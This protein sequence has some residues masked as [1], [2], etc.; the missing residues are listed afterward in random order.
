[1]SIDKPMP[2]KRAKYKI[3]ITVSICPIAKSLLNIQTPK[4]DPKKAPIS[5]TPPI[6]RSTRPCLQC[7]NVPEI[8]DATIWF[9]EVAT[10]T[11]VGMP[12]NI[13]NGV[14]KKPPPKPNMP[15]RN[16]TTPPKDNNRKMLTESSAIG[17]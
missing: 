17:R 9:A 4:I 11:L 10:A 6:L 15:D 5:N 13:N 14:I 16:P 8:E 2:V 12:M 7:P 3:E 1:M